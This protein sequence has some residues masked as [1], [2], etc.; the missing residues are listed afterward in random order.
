[1][2]EAWKPRHC[3]SELEGGPRK[4]KE[5]ERKEIKGKR[6]KLLSNIRER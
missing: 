5:K 2:G 6:S 1:M 4:E 3:G